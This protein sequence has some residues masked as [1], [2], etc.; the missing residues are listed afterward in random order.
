MSSNPEIQSDADKLLQRNR[1]LFILNAIA[2][3]LNG[4]IDL[5][6]TLKLA[7]SQVAGLLDMETGWIWL[8]HEETGESYLAAA[9]NL[10]RGLINNPTFLEGS[11]YCLDTYR[12]GDLS[13]AA[14][15]N[16]I[17][18]SR[19]KKVVDGA[20]GLRYH[21][22]IPL[23]AHDK[24]M[25]V[26]NVASADWQELS[27][28]ELRLLYTI[29]DMLS[30]AI[31][32]AR[33][34]TRS[35]ELGAAEERNRLAREIHD[36]LAQGLAAIAMQLETAD[37]L[38]EGN[39]GRERVQKTIRHALGLARANLDE[40]RRSV[41]DLR[42]APLEGRRLSEALG[43]LARSYNEKGEIKV[44]CETTGGERPL[45]V[46][47]EVGLYRI[48]QEALAN[49]AQ[50]ANTKQAII[51]LAVMPDS[52]T[53]SIED[54]GSGFDPSRVPS[55]RYGLVGLNER[56]RLLGGVLQLGSS[57]GMGTKIEV[58]VPLD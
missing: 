35:T 23:Y 40:A 33:L 19:L 57:P 32:R 5:D 8:L 51:R 3:S 12:A 39:T 58:R 14:N 21:S 4:S 6:Q 41:L 55:G 42:A 48:A 34:F 38:L 43:A 52:L 56:A 49:V 37:A 29:G 10:P 31:E 17:T 26:L 22:S 44:D 54:K 47:I 46:R 36:T 2:E 30:L 15:V 18:C 24:Q 16:V 25:G 9:L 50:H 28:D 11:C 27:A 7:L 13:G 20:D 53:L 1:E 45:P